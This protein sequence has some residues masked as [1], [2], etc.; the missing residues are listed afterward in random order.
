MKACSENL[1]SQCFDHITY[2]PEPLLLFFYQFNS[3]NVLLK[4]YSVQ[5]KSLYAIPFLF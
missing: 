1:S 2:T 5:A 4:K 3:E